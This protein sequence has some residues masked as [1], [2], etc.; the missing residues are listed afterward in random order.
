MV[1]VCSRLLRSI[2][3]GGGGRLARIARRK[4]RPMHDNAG[5][6]YRMQT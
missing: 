2:T 5:P 6:V 1:R 3:R 4:Q